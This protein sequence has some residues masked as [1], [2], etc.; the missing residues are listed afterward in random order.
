MKTI[1]RPHQPRLHEG[2]VPV[3]PAADRGDGAHTTTKTFRYLAAALRIALGWTFLWAF[4]DKTFGLGFATGRNPETGAVKV[5]G[6][7]AWLNGGSPTLGFLKFGTIGPLA[8]FYQSFAGAT[9]ADY[10]FMIGLAGIGIGL[11]FGIAMR[12]STISAVA[13]L[14]LMWS[15]TLLPANN[16]FLDD[17]LIY[18]IAALALLAVGAGHTLGLGKAWDKLTIVRNHPILK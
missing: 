14:V 15:A 16:P 8:G 4:L 10:L 6:P 5:F 11:T 3:T 12:L 2:V 1:A 13:M 18:G 7:D 9:W 17:H